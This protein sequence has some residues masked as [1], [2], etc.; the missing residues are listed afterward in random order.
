VAAL[1]LTSVSAF[2][3]AVMVTLAG[4]VRVGTVKAVLTVVGEENGFEPQVAAGAQLQVMPELVGSPA[5][6]AR[7]FMLGPLNMAGGGGV[8]N[9]TVGTMAVMVTVALALTALSA[10]EVT[11]M[12]TFPAMEGAV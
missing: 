10:T 3:V 6:W 12:V 7:S 11:V 9:E 1:V 5:I 4:V 2:E 8:T